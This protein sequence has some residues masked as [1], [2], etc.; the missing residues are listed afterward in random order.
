MRRR[1]FWGLARDPLWGGSC[2]CADDYDRADGYDRVDDYDRV[3]GYADDYVYV[4]GRPAPA[5]TTSA[6]SA[7]LEETPSLRYALPRCDSTV[8]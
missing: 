2:D 7:V 4:D 3:D 1:S 8:R 6:A 5:P